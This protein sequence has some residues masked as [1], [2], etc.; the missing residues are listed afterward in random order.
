MNAKAGK[1]FFGFGLKIPS[2]QAIHFQDGFLQA[3][4]CFGIVLTV[5]RHQH[6]RFIFFNRLYGRCLCIKNGIQHGKIV[7]ES[8]HLRQ[9]GD[10]YVVSYHHLPAVWAVVAGNNVQQRAFSGT[11]FDK[12]FTAFDKFEFSSGLRLAF[13][14]L[15]V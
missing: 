2:L 15:M 8:V 14:S 12:F 4:V 5:F 11:I 1:Y 10:G 13:R 6:T 3:L 7:S 9:V